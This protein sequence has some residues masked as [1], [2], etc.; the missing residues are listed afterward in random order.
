M[1]MNLTNFINNSYVKRHYGVFSAS[2]YI[3]I[4]GNRAYM[5]QW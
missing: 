2:T 3:L 5:W 4:Q 1:L